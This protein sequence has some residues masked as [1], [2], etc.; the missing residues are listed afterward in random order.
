MQPHHIEAFCRKGKSITLA[1]GLAFAT[2]SLVT[3]HQNAGG[4]SAPLHW[5]KGNTHTH[6]TNS[7]G[8][9]S[10]PLVAAWYRNNGYDFLYLTDHNKRTGISEIQKEIDTSNSLE[11]RKPF[12]LIPG[13]EVTEPWTE[14]QE[15]QALH[16]CGLD[17]K[18]VVGKQGGTTKREALQRCVDAITSAGGL[19][20]V[21][22]PNFMWSLT[23][24]DLYAMKGLRHFEIYNGHPVVNNYGGGGVPGCE[25]MWDVLL[26]RGR[27]FY[28]VAVDDAHHYKQFRRDLANPGRAWVVVRA[29][30]LSGKAIT[31]ALRDGNFYASTGVEL[32]D[33]T[34][35]DSRTL[36]VVIKQLSSRKFRTE[37]VGEYSKILATDETMT[38]SY[39]LKPN[40]KY[41]RAKVTSSN[42]EF[43]WT[44]PLFASKPSE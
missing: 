33:I 12:L 28:G 6:T 14:G 9:T 44:Q 7:D 37:F 23:T 39:T 5:Y 41:V 32:E 3:V 20:S 8:D 15:K 2:I 26:S 43:A 18:T 24:D 16:T 38:P 25:Q 17:T 11:Q 34:T 1:A 40:D 4:Q 31:A 19:P 27:L 21:N 10:P 13:E 22:H 42:G 30:E 35:T 29:A 36:G